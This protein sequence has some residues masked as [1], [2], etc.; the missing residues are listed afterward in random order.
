V[1]QQRDLTVYAIQD[2]KEL[3]DMCATGTVALSSRGSADAEGPHIRIRGTRAIA[4]YPR[5]SLW[6]PSPRILSVQDDNQ[7]G[8]MAD[9][10]NPLHLPGS[11]HS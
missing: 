9:L 11:W 7:L 5:Q 2:D 10:E 4:R 1:S 8:D 6:D 3:G